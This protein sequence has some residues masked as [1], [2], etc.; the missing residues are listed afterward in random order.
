MRVESIWQDVRYAARTL[1]KHTG[2][3]TTAVLTLAIGIG[4][5]TALFTVCDAVLFRRLPFT[6][7]ERLV[8]LWERRLRDGRHTGVAP[9]NYADWRAQSQRLAGI[10]ALDPS[11][12]FVVSGQGQPLLAPAAAVSADFFRL[13][14]T[15]M[16]IG[17]DFRPLEDRP[18]EDRVV[19]LSHGFWRARFGSDPGVT[20]RQLRLNG[21]SHTIVGV[22]PRDF[23][24][25]AAAVKLPPRS[26][27]DLWVPLALDPRQL[28][29][30]THPLR[31]FARLG[32]S[33]TL[34][35]AQAELDQIGRNLA[36]VYPD[37]NEDRGIAAVPLT[38]Q[39]VAD[40]RSSLL[41][42]FGASGVL[43]LIACVNVAHL[44]ATRA[45]ARHREIA[46]R[47]ALGASER[48]LRQQLLTEALLLTAT[49]A[50]GGV[51]LA[52]IGTRALSLYL[53]I[54]LPRAQGIAVDGRALVFSSVVALAIGLA[55]ARVPTWRGSSVAQP[56]REARSTGTRLQLRTSGAILVFQ[57]SLTLSLLIVA[58]LI[59]RSLG[60][61]LDVAPGFR[62]EH[63]MTAEITLDPNDYSTTRA[64]A[65]L[66][67]ALLTRLRGLPEVRS[68][69]A[70]AYLPL[71]GTDNSWTFEIEGRPAEPGEDRSAKYRPV[72]PGYFETLSIPVRRGRGFTNADR[73]DAPTVVMINA[74]AARSYWPGHNPIGRRIRIEG[75]PWR[76]VVG[77]VGD[78]RHQGLE[79]GTAP[80]L[81]YPFAQLPYPVR[82]A[83]FVVRTQGDPLLAASSVREVFR[84]VDPRQ[85]PPE[86]S[87]LDRIVGASVDRPRLRTRLLGTFAVLA[88]VLASVGIYG[89]TSFLI[90][91][92][93]RDFG[94]RAAL[95]ASSRDI[96]FLVLSRVAALVVVGVALGAVA[97]GLL[98]R[99]IAGFL[100]G[101]GTWDAATFVGASMLLMSVALF[102]SYVPARRAAAISPVEAMRAE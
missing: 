100:F 69:G 27:F 48:R 52:W 11:R 85:P 10:V 51:A 16:R 79:V 31:V 18:G 53:P 44:L 58:G 45:N 34:A 17:R 15:R 98:G 12:D 6:D 13:L 22:L 7:P 21:V 59:G 81:Y 26:S 36:H 76:T 37:A 67:D 50:A 56:L 84:E 47:R 94:V 71:S 80:E 82:R 72:S 33:S 39:I 63:V 74:A 30:G 60:A 64:I 23:E 25:P 57:V 93:T 91:Q 70:A 19:I 46:V 40:V 3:T 83:S 102:A 42:L 88:L 96:L 62:S 2:F 87:T 43:L 28:A 1:A 49:G 99:A 4:A 14:G 95:G 75:G 92:R 54:A 20:G 55:F 66:H 89:V 32:T 5:T 9:A 38:D 77:V 97:A 65:A 41:M 101:V 8:V 90:A 24:L 78:V 86:I 61:L 68:A 35:S 73:T 29:R